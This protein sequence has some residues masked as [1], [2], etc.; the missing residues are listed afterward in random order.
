M[1]DAKPPASL[2]GLDGDKVAMKKFIITVLGEDRPGIIAAVTNVLHEQDYNIEEV[3]QTI[4]QN[5]FS[6][7]FVVAGSERQSNAQLTAVLENSTAGFELFFHVRELSP[8]VNLNRELVCE[9]YV[10]TTQGP[11][12]KG[13]VAG[14]TA[15]FA[16]YQVNVAQLRAVFRGGDEPLNNTMIYEV[17]IPLSVDLNELRRAL[18]ERAKELDLEISIQ[19]RNIFE[20]MNRVL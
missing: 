1:T 8:H 16:A 5:Q 15:V 4:L 10:V 12:R 6:C 20:A 19:H 17:D 13:L 7:F 3:S 2:P 14:I 9:P 18:S 11:D